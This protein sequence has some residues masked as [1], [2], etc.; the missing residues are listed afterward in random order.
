MK[1]AVFIAGVALCSIV[2]PLLANWAIWSCIAPL[3]PRS[4]AKTGDFVS[5]GGIET[6]FERRGS[7]QPLI[8]I[9]A[10]ASHTSTWRFNIGALSS[11]H[12]VW[13]LS[14]ISEKWSP[15]FG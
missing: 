14:R 2:L 12:E 15:V 3:A 13:T 11:S 6:Y 1:T 5:V 4:L 9:P 10:G 7:G 8:L